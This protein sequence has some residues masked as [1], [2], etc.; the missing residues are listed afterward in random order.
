MNIY[1]ILYFVLMI[2]VFLSHGLKANGLKKLY[3]I[4]C[5]MLISLAILRSSSDP[6]WPDTT[7]YLEHF[8][9]FARSKDFLGSL[10]SGWEPGIIILA[11]LFGIISIEKQFFICVFG[12]IILVPIF[13]MIW[14]YS[15]NPLMGISVFYAMGFLTSTSI[16]RQWIAIAILTYSIRYIENRKFFKFLCIVLIAMC[17]HRTAVIFLI[18]YF[19]YGITVNVKTI[20]AC[21]VFG[22]GV[23]I[24]GKY[25]LQFLNFFARNKERI[26]NNG[27]IKLLIILWVCVFVAYILFKEK[28]DESKYKIPFCMILIG[29]TLQPL[30]F[31]FS[32][33][34]R[35]VYYFSLYMVLLLPVILKKIKE[36]NGNVMGIWCEQITLIVMLAWFLSNGFIEYIP[37]WSP[38][39]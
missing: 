25:I 32:T 8:I 16:Y 1:L 19:L 13:N 14:I 2:S 38:M 18:V 30:S 17:F 4:N 3:I 10:R 35:V 20:L 5:I 23:G 24:G 28:F 37:Y 9:Y 34:V 33:W 11:K 12:I 21:I 31:T 15:E 36:I 27:G 7:N 39:G 26:S 6:S 29:A 22:A